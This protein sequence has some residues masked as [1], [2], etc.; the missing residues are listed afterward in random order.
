M[1]ETEKHSQSE[2]SPHAAVFERLFGRSWDSLPALNIANLPYLISVFFHLREGPQMWGPFSAAIKKGHG[3]DYRINFPSNIDRATMYLALHDVD[4]IPGTVPLDHV[5]HLLN[6]DEELGE[7]GRKII[8]WWNSD[9]T[10]GTEP[11]EVVAV[12]S[13]SGDPRGLIYY[14]KGLRLPEKTRRIYNLFP[15]LQPQTA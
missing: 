7:A 12:K 15:A 8:A 3:Y 10:I 13:T 1:S 5:K 9:L 6:P 11:A 2:Q 4:D 14:H